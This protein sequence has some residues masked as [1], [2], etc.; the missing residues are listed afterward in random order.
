MLGVAL[1]ALESGNCTAVLLLLVL[2]PYS[3]FWEV[4]I[5]SSPEP[6]CFFRLFLSGFMPSASVL[7]VLAS[8]GT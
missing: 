8:V 6:T 3:G 2:A 4:A 5:L 7:G 1:V